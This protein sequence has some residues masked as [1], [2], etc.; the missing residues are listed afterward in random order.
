MK[1]IHKNQKGQII[2]ISLVVM[3]ILLILSTALIQYI[4]V[5]VKSERHTIARD[6][7]LQLA[8]A[9]IDQ[10]IYQLN[11]NS[12]YD[13]ETTVL[14]NGVFDISVSTINATTKKITATGY[15][16]N[17]TNPQATRVI[18]AIVAINNSIISFN[19]GVQSGAGGFVLNGG[20]IVNGNIY[21][22]G[23]VVATNGVHING[24]ATASNPPSS[25]ADQTNNSPAIP[26]SSITFANNSA[27]QDFAQSFKI[28]TAQPMNNIQFYIKK[29]GTPSNIT[30]RIVN[31]NS[32]SPSSEVLMTGTILASNVT[33]NFGWITVTMPSAPILDPSQTYWMVLDASS[34]SSKYYIIGANTNGY[35]D[36]LAKIGKY[37]T[38]W[39]ATSPSDLD[40]YFQIFLGGG[41]STLGGSTYVGG[42]YVGTTPSD[43]AWAH[44][45]IGVSASGNLYCQIG[46]YN[47]KACDTSRPDPDPQPMPLSDAN[48]QEWKDE[49]AAG[50]IIT[51]NYHVGW[52]GDTIGPKVI[53]GNLLIDGG[54]TL[55]VSGTLYIHG[56]ITLS[57]GGEIVLSSSYGSASGIIVSDG[58]VI[59]NGGSDFA[60]SG[61]PGSYP[62]LITTSACPVAPECNGN[63]A[64][65]LSGGAGTVAI[66][67][68]NGEVLI[69][70]GSSLKMVTAKKITMSGGATLTYD[71]GLVSPN[72]SSGPGG[73]WSYVPGTYIIEQ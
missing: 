29:V 18:K 22:N 37:G 25:F 13:G 21:S 8:E 19:Y 70:G 36:G 66:I 58:Y 61:Q 46:S 72:F 52:A 54:G 49:A 33:T 51:G 7:A 73:S 56:T 67:A 62:F 64:V 10:A 59:I 6:Q 53:T 43:I 41:Y 1:I 14:G 50:G 23:D 47:N 57:G 44:E 17:N 40:S 65:Y 11:Q 34:N 68:Q 3:A 15:L 69:N 30:V 12:N 55:T 60:G 48:I 39:S 24:S 32:G 45:A 5:Y 16:P 38:S 2:L 42:V 4:S 63:S 35:A 26:P 71:S 9:G 31:D 28:S 27:T 20:S